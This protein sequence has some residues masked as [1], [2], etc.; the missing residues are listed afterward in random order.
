MGESEVKAMFVY[1]FLK[2]VEWPMD[3]S[4]GLKDPFVVLIIGEGA[5]ADAAEHFLESKTIG[6]RPLVVGRTQWNQSLAGARAVFVLERDP[7]KLRHILDAA[8]TAGVLSI[9]EG[10]AF[11]TRGGVI[12]LLVED[13]K[14]RFDVDTTAAQNA[15][16][17]ISS[18]LLALTRSVR[19]AT[20]RSGS[21][22]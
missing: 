15:R 16:L 8:A 9:G 11:T 19:S 22:Q 6:A 4:A 7:R 14:V 13:R 20:D 5:T 12:T 17:R 10:E 1:N 18:K 3:L 2:F 21:Q